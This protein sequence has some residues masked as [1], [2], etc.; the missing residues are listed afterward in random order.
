MFEERKI[1]L[2]V[3]LVFVT[4]I[5]LGE[6]GTRDTIKCA[7]QCEAIDDL[8]SAI[9]NF[10]ID[11]YKKINK[12]EEVDSNVFFSPVSVATAL[13]MLLLGAGGDTK[14]QME[15]VLHV[16]DIQRN[17]KL[18]TMYT[19]LNENLYGKTKGTEL[20]SANKLYP[21]KT[22]AVRE[23]FIKAIETYYKGSIEKLDF[24]Q[25]AQATDII[26]KWVADQTNQLI[27][28][29]LQPGD[30][31]AMTVFA[32]INAIYFKGDW[33]TQFNPCDTNVQSFYVQDDET[34]KVDMMYQESPFRYYHNIRLKAQFLDLPYVGD[35]LSMVIILPDEKN[36]LKDL[37]KDITADNLYDS[38]LTLKAPHTGRNVYVTLPKMKFKWKN[39]LSSIL[40]DMGMKKLFSSAVDLNGFSND[41]RLD[42]S[43]VIHEAFVD[44]NEEG[45]EA[46]AVTV[47]A[48]GRSGYSPP[49]VKVNCNHPFMFLIYDKTCGVILFIGKVMN[50]QSSNATAPK[51]KVVEVV[52]D[53]LVE[54]TLQ[55]CRDRCRDD[56]YAKLLGERTRKNP[57]TDKCVECRGFRTECRKASRSSMADPYA[58]LFRE[59]FTFLRDCKNGCKCKKIWKKRTRNGKS[60]PCDV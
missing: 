30:I 36:G 6:A 49:P 4:V 3:V 24:K 22:L 52:S 59:D 28:E 2:A 26:N 35:R 13:A 51:Q 1:G 15:N 19:C 42:V 31:S 50:P 21:D 12:Q 58:K 56:C 25:S 33:V 34:V 9:N 38:L 60:D 23:K 39:E 10:A 54:T 29:V 14:R 16:E 41:S 48:G 5:S 18:H 11:I 46:A 40:E 43:K 7:K 53:K 37:V 45:T 17:A 57:V 44:V 8:T 32:L 20:R 27:K 55:N 47:I